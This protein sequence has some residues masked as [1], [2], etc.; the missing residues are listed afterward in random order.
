MAFIQSLSLKLTSCQYFLNA[1]CCS[2][3]NST[4]KVSQFLH[5]ITSSFYTST[6]SSFPLTLM[7]PQ[8]ISQLRTAITD[9]LVW[10][11]KG[12][13]TLLLSRCDFF[14]HMIHQEVL[15]QSPSYSMVCLYFYYF[16][17]AD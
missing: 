3:L 17:I 14:S 11:E 12:N 9:L 10:M 16:Q 8:Q 1:E 13:S 2:F 7:F 15:Y 5:R 6:L 4:K